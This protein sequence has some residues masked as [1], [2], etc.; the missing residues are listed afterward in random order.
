MDNDSASNLHASGCYLDTG[1]QRV[2]DVAELCIECHSAGGFIADGKGGADDAGE[3][4]EKSVAD[5]LLSA[6]EGI[7]RTLYILY[8]GWVETIYI[9]GMGVGGLGTRRSASRITAV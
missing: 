7:I 8:S 4:T 3:R 6:S 9:V 2:A 1:L 5:G